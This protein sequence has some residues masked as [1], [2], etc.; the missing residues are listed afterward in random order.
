[1]L[2]GQAWLPDG[3]TVVPDN[4]H[5]EYAWWPENVA[6]WPDEAHEPLRMMAGL[7]SPAR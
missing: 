2:V 5:D 4:E 7:V 6:D 1:M 3:A